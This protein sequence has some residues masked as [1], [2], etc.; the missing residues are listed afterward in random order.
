[1]GTRT[2]RAQGIDDPGHV[3]SAQKLGSDRQS[4]QTLLHHGHHRALK[5]LA[6]GPRPRRP[7]PRAVGPHP[8]A[9]Q[10]AAELSDDGARVILLSPDRAARRVMGRNM[11]DDT[12]R[13][14]A[15]R[16]GHAQ[17]SALAP[18]AADV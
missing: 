4:T 17:A 10:Q 1:M 3:K 7:V 12:R 11:A 16:V 5:A 18:S 6:L 13:S 2:S 9:S 15:A 8:S 14:A